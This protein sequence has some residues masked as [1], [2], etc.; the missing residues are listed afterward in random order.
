M[1]TVE[2]LWCSSVA[3][4]LWCSS[5]VPVEKVYKELQTRRLGAVAVSTGDTGG[6]ICCD[7]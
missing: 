4:E 3:V 7:T 5:R 2:K 6:L 1:L